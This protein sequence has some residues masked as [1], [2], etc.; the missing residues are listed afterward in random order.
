MDDYL[1]IKITDLPVAVNLE[2]VVLYG[3]EVNGDRSVQ[4]PVTI[5]QALISA[6]MSVA[7]TARNKADAALDALPLKVEMLPVD[8]TDF[9][10]LTI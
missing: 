8:E 4:V 6:A 1:L 3:V 7:T 9:P 5:L 10:E 2:G